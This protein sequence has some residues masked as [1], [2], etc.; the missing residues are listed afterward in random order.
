MRSKLIQVKVNVLGVEVEAKFKPTKV[1]YIS[2]ISSVQAERCYA[3]A[4]ERLHWQEQ[5]VGTHIEVSSSNSSIGNRRV[6]VIYRYVGSQRNE[7]L[8]CV[9]RLSLLSSKEDMSIKGELSLSYTAFSQ[10]LLANSE[11]FVQGN[12]EFLL[13]S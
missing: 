4:L 5:D 1:D 13:F 3:K 8:Q 12:P 6:V 10:Y 2:V 9:L 11:E 7:S